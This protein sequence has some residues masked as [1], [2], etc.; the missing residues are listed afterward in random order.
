MDKENQTV[1]QLTAPQVDT[2]IY[3]AENLHEIAD[4]RTKD[5]VIELF[6]KL[7][8]I[9]VCGDDEQRELW[10]TAPRGSI[11]EFGDYE[12]YLEGGEVESHEE[13]EE[14]WLSAYPDT[15]KWYLLSTTVYKDI[16]SVFIDGKLVLQIQPEPQGQY[17][18]DKS[19]LAGWLLTAV[20]EAIASLKAGRYNE[21]VSKNLPYRQRLGKILREDYWRIFPEEKEEY[22]KD[23]EPYEAARFV[24]LVKKQPADSPVSCLPEMTAALFFDICRLGYEANNY[25]GIEKL[26]SK[27]MYRA[28]ADGRDEG[29]L[30]LDESS[31]E[32]FNTWY[33]D[34]TH[35]GGHPW[36]V[37]RGG[38]S[39]HISLYVR[40][41]EKGWW[42][43]LA[44]SSLGRSVEIVK[45][46]LA[47]EDHGL[48]IFLT[49]GI[50]LAAM[51]TGTDYIGIVPEGII[52][53]YCASLFQGEKILD[54]MNLPQESREQVEKA[55]IW[56]PLR[57]VRLACI[58]TF[59]S[60]LEV[61]EFDAAIANAEAEYSSDNQLIDAREALLKLK[62]KHFGKYA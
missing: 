14:L 23:I 62:R 53:R 26:T 15:Q 27:E 47:L 52:P 36:E 33:H 45:F 2:L 8:S 19:E 40:H 21:D 24:D 5:L 17:P 49:D 10:L 50:E 9:T 44:G 16:Y 58:G 13:F 38:N 11:E 55:A 32:A 12:N 43:R 48:P 37:C 7:Q 56:Y 46:Y 34:K 25:E 29:L 28:H 3:R 59:D 41:D 42:L 18:Y 57:E 22:L 20:K 51:L 30:N 31:A 4:D 61:R 1:K 60:M 39:T 6:Q 54:F 35:Y